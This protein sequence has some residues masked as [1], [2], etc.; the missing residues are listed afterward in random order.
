MKARLVALLALVFVSA[1]FFAA[2]HS[3]A[4]GDA[5]HVHDG[6][7]CI[8]ASIVKKSSDMDVAAAPAVVL[9]DR[10]EWLEPTALPAAPQSRAARFGTIRAP[11]AHA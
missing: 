1:Q 2:A 4:Y 11:P 8:V 10:A 9:N 6:H 3:A 5:D 7:P